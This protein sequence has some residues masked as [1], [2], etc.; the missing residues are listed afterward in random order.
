ME[1]PDKIYLPEE[2]FKY[3]DSEKCW[4][5]KPL[6]GIEYVRTN[7]FIEKAIGWIDDNN[8]N[9]GCFFEGWENDFKNYMEGK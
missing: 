1:A 6:G 7:A 4:N 5:Y 8:R 9:G 3:G 2:P